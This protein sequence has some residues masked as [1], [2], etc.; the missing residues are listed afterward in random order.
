MESSSISVGDG[1]VK[2]FIPFCDSGLV[3]F[4]IVF[5]KV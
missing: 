5:L 2:S 1:G 4:R 3:Y